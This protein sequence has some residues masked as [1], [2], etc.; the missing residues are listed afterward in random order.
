MIVCCVCA[1]FCVCV[2][3]HLYSPAQSTEKDWETLL[4]VAA[5][6][7]PSIRILTSNTIFTEMNQFLGET[8]D[9][10]AGTG[11]VQDEP[12]TVCTRKLKE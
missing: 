11:K 2:Y 12:R 1:V 5:V 6:S 8:T 9:C 3:T 7:K 10:R 4:C